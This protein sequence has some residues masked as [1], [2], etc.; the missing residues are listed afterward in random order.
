[1]TLSLVFR[2]QAVMMAFFGV[3]MLFV[4]GVM[5]ESFNMAASDQMAGMMQSMSPLMLAVAYI[6]W[7]MPNWASESLKSIGLVFA[8]LHLTW[9]ILQYYQMATGVFPLDAAGIGGL[10][11][12]VILAI[13]FYW[14][15]RA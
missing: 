11:P 10:A 15:S 3:M 13:L 14:K 7:Q 2:I 8:V 6:S 1:M 4:P 9:P 5:M 12:D